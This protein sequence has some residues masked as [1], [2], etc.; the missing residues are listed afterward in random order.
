MLGL[1]GVH[2]L[3]G[4]VHGGLV[5]GLSAHAEGGCGEGGEALE[6]GVVGVL[7]LL[8]HSGLGIIH[9]CE[10]LVPSPRVLGLWE[11][12]LLHPWGRD[13]QALEIVRP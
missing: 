13:G 6:R 2:L 5:H 8:W 4:L 9:L 1:L 11:T 3:S 10:F 12:L 7:L